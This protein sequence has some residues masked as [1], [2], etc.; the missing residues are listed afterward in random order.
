[1]RD[2]ISELADE[3]ADTTTTPSDENLAKLRG[4][5]QQLVNLDETITTMETDLKGLRESR[6]NLAMKEMPDYILDLDLDTIGLASAGVDI[7]L[8]DYCK[9][10]IPTNWDE[11]KRKESFAHLVDVGGGDL[12]KATLVLAAGRDELDTIRALAELIVIVTTLPCEDDRVEKIIEWFN[13][14]GQRLRP[15]DLDVDV[16]L[17]VVW[18]TLTSFVKEQTK[19]GTVLDL[20]KLGAT[21]GHIVKIKKR[22]N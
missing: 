4:M 17:A 19:K 3:A 15:I 6:N 8:V 5:G 13:E 11:D 14:N 9:A 2:L 12:I 7:I 16:K 20:E 18:S 22:K 21:V 10:G 1:M